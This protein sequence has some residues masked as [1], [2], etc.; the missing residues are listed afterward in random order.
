MQITETEDGAIKQA[1][2]RDATQLKEK[3]RALHC[4]EIRGRR[5]DEWHMFFRKM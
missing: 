1:I 2:D 5:R 3:R 4:T